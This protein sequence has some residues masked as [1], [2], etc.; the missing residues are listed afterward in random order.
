MKVLLYS[1]WPLAAT[2]LDPL[3]RYISEHEPSWEVWDQHPLGKP[4]VVVTCDELSA[5]PD[6]PLKI[7]IFH[8]LASKGQAFSTVRQQQFVERKQDYAAPS[9]YYR[10]LLLSLGV[11]DDRIFIAGLTKFDGLERKVLYA[12]THNPQL[13]AIPVVQ[14]RIYE[15]P[16]VKVHLHMY[17]RTGE[18]EHHKLFRSYY[19][20]HEDREDIYD[21]LGWA[22][23]IIGDM[24]SIVVEALA[25]G[26]RAIQ[27]VNPDW[28]SFYRSN[29][30]QEDELERLP[31]VY[32]PRKYGLTVG[33]AEALIEAVNLM[34]VGSGSAAVVEW[35]RHHS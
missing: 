15:I 32:F 16:D 9:P 24:G 13:S 1:D 35:I 33:S 30:V 34:P 26:K 17:T 6:A 11:S 18:R 2:Y 4:D 23:T 3:R 28:E 20:Q 29:G 27:V 22:D 21:L 10:D 8:G 12:P 25:L 19:P 31:E 14:D 7:C 5:A